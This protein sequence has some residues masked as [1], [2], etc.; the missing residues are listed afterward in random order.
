MVKVVCGRNDNGHDYLLTCDGHA[1]VDGGLGYDPVCAGCTTLAYTLAQN[2]RDLAASGYLRH[3][4]DVR[5]E[6]GHILVKASPKKEFAE[7]VK[8][9][10]TF[11]LTGYR[12]LSYNYPAAV[13]VTEPGTESPT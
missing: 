6:K 11:T 12:L 4:P 2:M 5:M 7:L 13:E 1:E 8:A 3:D 10:Y 9:A